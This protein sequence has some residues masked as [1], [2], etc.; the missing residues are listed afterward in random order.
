[1]V[2]NTVIERFGANPADVSSTTA[3]NV[4]TPIYLLDED[5]TIGALLDVRMTLGPPLQQLLLSAL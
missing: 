1:M 5:T 2:I 3:M 4:I